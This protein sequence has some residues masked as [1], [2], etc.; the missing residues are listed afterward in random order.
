MRDNGTSTL[1][2]MRRQDRRTVVVGVEQH[3]D[4]TLV[5]GFCGSQQQVATKLV[6]SVQES[7]APDPDRLGNGGVNIRCQPSAD[8]AQQNR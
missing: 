8:A 6:V 1:Q 2:N 5:A 4:P 7:I 3:Q